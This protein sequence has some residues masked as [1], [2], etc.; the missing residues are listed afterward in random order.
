LEKFGLAAPQVGRNIQLFVISPEL[1]DQTG[2]HLV[3]IN[4]KTSG[5]SRKKI[6]IEEGCLSLPERYDELSR[7]EKI[8]VK[9]RDENGKKFKV[10][11][12]GL[13]ARLFVHETDHLKGTLYI[14]HL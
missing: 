7:P 1:T 5:A 9:A 8:T 12:E 10:R 13:L 2:G 14:D 4:P 6:A 11:G 3:F